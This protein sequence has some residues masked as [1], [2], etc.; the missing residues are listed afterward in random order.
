MGHVST[1]SIK[2]SETV[3][4]AARSFPKARSRFNQAVQ[5]LTASHHLNSSMMETAV[6]L[7]PPHTDTF[8][9]DGVVSAGLTRYPITLGHALMV[10]TGNVDL[11][12]LTSSDFSSVLDTAR[13]VAL[14]M[15]STMNVNRCGLV[16]DGSDVV[17]LIPLHGVSKEWKPVVYEV[18]EY[19]TTFP[20][21]LTSKNGPK[22]ADLFLDG[23]QHR[24]NTSTRIVQPFNYHFDGDSLNQNIFARIIRGEAPQWRIWEDDTHVAFL[25][26]FGNTS[27]FTVLV[28]RKHL[29]SDIFRLEDQ[30]YAGMVKAAHVVA[31]HLKNAFKVQR[32]G[33]IFEGYEID[34]AHVKLIPVHEKEPSQIPSFNATVRSASFHH[35]YEGYLTSQ[36]GPLTSDLSLLSEEAIKIRKCMETRT[37]IISPPKTWHNSDT[38][39][40]KA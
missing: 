29:Q 31:Q 30:D 20:G 19:H 37:A 22:M 18:K 13:Q 1:L 5:F 27:G 24:I 35:C 40:G 25:T 7:S 9:E 38:H 28:P 4:Y 32:C 33:L 12:S 11:M 16:S 21:Y 39:S 10:C 8:Y 17:S 15:C 23:V 6:L 14:A 2:T 26:P 34:Y 36:F 3:S